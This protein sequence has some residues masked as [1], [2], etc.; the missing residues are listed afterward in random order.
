MIRM[1]QRVLATAAITVGIFGLVGS[2]SAQS[3]LRVGAN[4]GNVP[5]EFQN[6]KGDI[7]GFEIDLMNEVG[8]RIGQKVEFVNIPF[9]GLF[10]A[11]QSGQIDAAVSS[12]TITKKRLESVSFA[13]PYYDSDQSLTVTKASGIKNLDG[14]SGKTVGVDTGSTGDIW[15]TANTAK[16][17]LG[18]I[19]RFEGL[20]PA[21]LDLAAGRIDG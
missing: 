1:M 11:V 9:Q 13:Q 7:V 20:N 2:A 15:A 10:A 3:N 16:Y 12:I 4:V 17:K 18:E 19:R 5:W 6:E 21:M 8:K 14:M